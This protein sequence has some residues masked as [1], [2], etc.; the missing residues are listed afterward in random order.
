MIYH[1]I[2]IRREPPLGTISFILLTMQVARSN[3]QNLGAKPYTERVKQWR[4]ERLAAAFPEYDAATLIQYSNSTSI[5]ES[6][7]ERDA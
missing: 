7:K 3:M 2:V 1:H 5:H 6:K 4:A